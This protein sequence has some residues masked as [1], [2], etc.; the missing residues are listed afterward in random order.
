MLL[1]SPKTLLLTALSL[2]AFSPTA[3][4]QTILSY[5]F[6]TQGKWVAVPS[7]GVAATL[8]LGD[9]ANGSPT[10]KSLKL[11]YEFK[12][13]MGYV[14]LR[15]P[16]DLPLPEN[17]E[18]SFTLR[19]DEPTGASNNLETKLV[20]G[21]INADKA[22]PVRDDV[23]WVNQRNIPYPPAGTWKKHT[24]TKRMFSFAWGPS[25][26]SKPLKQLGAL[27]FAL[28]AAFGDDNV[29]PRGAGRKGTLWIDDV[30]IRALPPV[31]PYTGSPVGTA[32]SKM[33]ELHTPDNLFDQDPKT[34][35][36]SDAE[37]KAPSYTIDFGQTREFGGL[38]IEWERGFHP[39]SFTVSLSEDSKAWTQVFRGE[40]PGQ[41]RALVP[42]PATQSRYVR[43]DFTP[44][45][46]PGAVGIQ[47]LSIEPVEFAD[48]PNQMITSVAKTMPRGSFPRYFSGEQTYWTVMGIPSDV[49]ECLMN[50]E[51]Q[52]EVV[53]RGWMI[54]P[55]VT[56][57]TSKDESRHFTWAD[58][59]HTQELG[60]GF[61]PMPI[62]NRASEGHELKVT[63]FVDGKASDTA[64][65]L[66]YEIHNS[67]T[68]PLTGTLHLAL[69]PFQIL[70]PWQQLNIEGGVGH[71][72]S[73][74]VVNGDIVV[75]NANRIVSHSRPTSIAFAN[76]DASITPALDTLEPVTANNQT[77][78]DSKQ[79]ASGLINYDFEIKPNSSR[80]FWLSI[81]LHSRERL[82]RLDL[83]GFE[84]DNAMRA[85]AESTAKAW[86][87][88]LVR[89][90]FSLPQDAQPLLETWYAS[91]GYILTNFDGS[92]FQP[93]S[94]TYERS[95]MRD[96]YFTGVAMES[97]GFPEITK[98][99]IQAYAK[100][101]L[102]YGKV[103]AVIDRRGIDPTDEHDS[104][105][106]YIASILS[107]YHYTND[108]EFLKSRFTSIVS[109]VEYLQYLI[110]LRST[111]EFANTDETKT[112]QEPGKPA[113][114]VRAFYGLVPESISHEGYSAKPM[115]SYWDTF[116]TYK[117]LKDAVE[118]ARILEDNNRVQAWSRVRDEFSK[119][120]TA[121]L[122]YAQKV[123]NIDYVPGCVELGDFDS[124]S[125]T[126]VLWPTEAQDI[127]PQGTLKNTFDR[128][129]TDFLKRQK[130]QTWEAFTPYE[131]RHV[132]ALTRM[133]QRNKAHEVLKWY[134]S[135]QRPSNWRQ[136]QEVVWRDER[137]PK[138]IGDSPHT[139]CA[140]DFMNSFRALFLYERE[141]DK[142]L[143]LFA[144]VPASWPSQNKGVGIQ[145]MPSH[146]GKVNAHV[147]QNGKR[148]TFS[149]EGTVVPPPGGI[150]VVVPTDL[151]I[152][153]VKVNGQP[154]ELSPTGEVIIR[155]IPAKII[156]DT[157]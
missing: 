134:M 107:H 142:S 8:T 73:L 27:E 72:E 70:P 90:R 69:R 155:E 53:K 2:L 101:Q 138:F 94:R 25:L 56:I 21:S 15:L 148:L 43:L 3:R 99:F 144:G 115:H 51:G 121:S 108:K 143:V 84:P 136:W 153:Q 37:D 17:Y 12:N 44:H 147:G 109:A 111:S 126:I 6:D 92:L 11:D 58:G 117:G 93:G 131:L 139:W 157:F 127:I 60:L 4:A 116:F 67:G 114:P 38:N 33:C 29:G 113:V 28:T 75:N 130:E 62:V 146:Y 65:N 42:L 50:E 88:F 102:P 57:R 76:L 151:A 1:P 9:D 52:V 20:D 80:R 77:L 89:T 55:T 105:G 47:T 145:D 16:V 124:T 61:L 31:V 118:I 133:G 46:K 110:A 129:Y 34:A 83:T 39:A 104:T 63:G 10:S 82:E 23:W 64:V 135:M 119:N 112:R 5:T 30:S 78:T 106:Q 19:G 18:V 100:N 59:K 54:D 140:S 81:P 41:T 40:N 96:G 79:L 128:Y 13:G 74:E 26:G 98:L 149:I 86:Q 22:D 91:V 87:T 103:P 122:A 154:G 132:G 71:I 85:R 152:R 66:C 14:I 68:T 95:W 123:H 48:S 137:N 141:S 32:T 125:T 45:E 97:A 36:Q 24:L 7:E 150:A 35:W 49:R 156:V 120:L